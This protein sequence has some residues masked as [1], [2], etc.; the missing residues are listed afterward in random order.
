MSTNTIFLIVGFLFVVSVLGLVAYSIYELT[1]FA[2]HKDHYRN[3]AG[4]KRFKSPRLD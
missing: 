2:S 4:Q 3:S 1:P